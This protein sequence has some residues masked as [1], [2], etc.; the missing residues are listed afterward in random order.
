MGGISQSLSQQEGGQVMFLGLCIPMCTP[1]L[2]LWFVHFSFHPLIVLS[3]D[4]VRL[5]IELASL[6]LPE[7]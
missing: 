6:L 1:N 5:G 7:T 2:A 4:C 3:A